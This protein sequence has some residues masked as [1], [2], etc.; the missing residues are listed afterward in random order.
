MM[1]PVAG[2]ALPQS[3]VLY[4]PYDSYKLGFFKEA[5]LPPAQPQT[6][7]I[8]ITNRYESRQRISP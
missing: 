8:S 2:D 7:N 3:S 6:Y 5:L 1:F 4:V